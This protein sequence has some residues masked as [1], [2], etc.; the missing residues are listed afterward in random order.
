MLNSNNYKYKINIIYIFMDY[1][2]ENYTIDELINIFDINNDEKNDNKILNKKIKKYINKISETYYEKDRNL[3]IK[4]L[5]NAYNKIINLNLKGDI[6]NVNLLNEV[7]N[8]EEY[9]DVIEKDNHFIYTRNREPIVQ[10][11]NVPIVQGQLNPTLRNINKSI[12][13]L[14]TQMR[15]NLF[16]DTN[17]ITYDLSEPLINVMSIRVLSI[18]IKHSWYTFDKN[19][20]TTEFLVDNSFIQIPDGNYNSNDLI[21]IINNDLSNNNMN[22]I[23][24]SY[25]ENTGKTTIANNDTMP[26]TITFYNNDNPGM[27]KKNSN[28]GWLLGFKTFDASFNIIL[29]IQPSSMI[30]SIGLLDVYGPRYILLEIDDFNNNHYNKNFISVDDTHNN[31]KF[32]SYYTPDISLNDPSKRLTK[33]NNG[34]IIWIDSGLKQSEVYT[35]LQVNKERQSKGENFNKIT[36]IKK[37]DIIAKLPVQYSTN[38]GTLIIGYNFI[39]KNERLYYG[40]V[41][42]K[43][44]KVALYNDAGQLLNLNRQDFS[45]T[46]QTDELYQY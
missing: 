28:F 24:F 36:S 39:N 30:T 14:D 19:Y 1:N 34:N 20:G 43:R 22:Y 41:N 3:M 6:K 25:N 11:H 2:I 31:L 8:R 38:F 33:D 10:G 27:K 45:I 26:H 40:P 9:V 5:N 13:S 7:L 35:I 37:N 17:N 23:V 29:T 21:N 32:P 42:I 4:F 46:L 44:M 18:E 16:Q 15:Q 12:V